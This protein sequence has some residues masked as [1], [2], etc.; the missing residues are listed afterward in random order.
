VSCCDVLTRDLSI[1]LKTFFVIYILM[2]SVEF[3][4]APVMCFLWASF[5]D[6][7]CEDGVC[8]VESVVCL[9]SCG[10]LGLWTP[11]ERVTFIR[12]GRRLTAVLLRVTRIPYRKTE[13][14]AIYC[15]TCRKHTRQYRGH[16]LS[17]CR[18]KTNN[19]SSTLFLRQ[20][21]L[22]QQRCA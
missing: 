8:A 20:F 13:M 9:L 6:L 22:P 3:L 1:T 4:S 15:P 18:E 16:Y 17:I 2:F 14:K 10:K 21:L 19:N 7:Y 11:S 12:C 5:L